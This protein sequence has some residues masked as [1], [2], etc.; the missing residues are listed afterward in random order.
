MSISA[1]I[2]NQIPAALR[3]PGV[4]I[5]FDDRLA[6]NSAFQGR[7]L[8]IGQRLDSGEREALELERV[9]NAE[10]A[11]RYYG[12]GS[13]LAEMLRHSLN[14]QP[15][16]ET[17]ALPL[18]DVEEGSGGVK[19]TGKIALAG[20]ASAAGAMVLYLA[21]YRV[22]IGV[23]VGDDGDGIAQALVDAINADSRLPVTAT[24][25]ATVASEVDLECRWAGETGD[26]ID[27][28]FAALGED[29]IAGVTPTI[30]EMTGG[31]S[32]PDLVDAIAAL[33]PEQYNWI[34]CPYT[35]TA[36]LTA[37]KDELDDRFGPMRQIG[38]RAFAAFRGTHGETGT[39]GGNHNSPHLTVCL[40][41]TSDAADE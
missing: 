30:T 12:R 40:L 21:G 38:G 39:F 14:A 23:A 22:R 8:V 34:A 41:Y 37:L 29:R 18:D 16:L 25:N 24:V 4:Y 17:W 6:G 26:D 19:S 13:M 11:E 9:T 32:N 33:G 10:Q 31:A 15:Y 20:S 28:R 36:N 1:G 7:L 2:F 35:D 5:E 27:I 3:V